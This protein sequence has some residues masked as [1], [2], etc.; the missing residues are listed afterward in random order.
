MTFTQ[1]D[2]TWRVQA[3]PV[4]FRDVCAVLGTIFQGAWGDPVGTGIDTICDQFSGENAM[5]LWHKNP[6][7]IY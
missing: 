5:A 1:E 7:T 3:A 2:K 6:E 4:H